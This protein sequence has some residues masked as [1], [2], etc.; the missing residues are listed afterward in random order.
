MR[1]EA[2]EIQADIGIKP[3]IKEN[4]QQTCHN[5]SENRSHCSTCNPHLWHTKHAENQ[6]RIHNDIDD[7]TNSLGNH[8][9]ECPTGCLK[10]TFK[11]HLH[12]DANGADT[13]NAQISLTVPDNHSAVGLGAEEKAAG[14][15]TE[16]QEHQIA[17]Q[18]KKDTML[19]R[20]IGTLLIF[21]T[22]RTGKQCI[23]AHTGAGSHRYH[24]ILHGKCQRNRCQRI[25][26][27]T[28][29]KDTVHNIVHCLYQHGNNHRQCHGNQQFVYRHDTHFIFLSYSL[30]HKLKPFFLAILFFPS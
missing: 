18:G 29:Y 19:C 15:Q 22:Q 13:A 9:I 7:S 11:I 14:D 6:N 26:T 4:S 30:S 21:L 25:L 16:Q 1:T 24:Q 8:G 28:G 20:S 17:T 12:K 5:L 27:D 2:P 10:D 3:D 23:H